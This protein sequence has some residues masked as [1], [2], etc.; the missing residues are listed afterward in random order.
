MHEPTIPSPRFGFEWDVNW[1]STAGQVRLDGMAHH[2]VAVTSN[3]EIVTMGP[4]GDTVRF[5][6]RTG[7][8]TRSWAAP[9]STGHALRVATSRDTETVWIAD[10]GDSWKRLPSGLYGSSR[11]PWERF[12]GCVVQMTLEGQ[13]LNRLQRPLHECYEDSSYC[14]T[15]VVVD[16]VE[17]GGSGDVWVADGYGASLVHKFSP[18]G[19]LVLT[20]SGESGAGRFDE[21]HA[22]HIDRRRA[23]PELYVADREN[24]RIQ[25]FDLQGGY[26]RTVG[27]GQL[28]SPGAFAQ[29]REHLVVAELDG[30][31]VVLDTD[32]EVVS[33]IGSGELADRDVPGWPNALDKDGR[34]VRPDLRPGRLHTPHGLAS[35][36][37]GNL[38]VSEWVIGGRLI[39]LQRL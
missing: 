12:D 1:S 28:I 23:T 27:V 21:P 26:L 4:A 30:R 17:H 31:L 16:E 19:D 29:S 38:L 36:H 32:D 10:N 39:R 7:A 25:V 37:D 13:E 15:D 11:E 3:G 6:D 9:V 14:P 22:I 33:V 35:D 8:Q 18:D 2:G 24:R 34:S 20:L 5:L